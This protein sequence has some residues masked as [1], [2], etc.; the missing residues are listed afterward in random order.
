M[1]AMGE[2]GATQRRAAFKRVMEEL[3]EKP[4]SWAKS[5]GLPNANALYNFL[6]GRSDSLSTA[7]LEAL[8]SCKNLTVSQVVGETAIRSRVNTADVE[9]RGE[10]QAGVWKEA[11]E[12]PLEDRFRITTVIEPAQYRQKAYGLR[13]CGNSMNEFYADGDILICVSIWDLDDAILHEDHVIVHRVDKNGLHEATCKE[14]RVDDSGRGWLVA[15]SS[16]PEFQERAIPI[17]WPY[18]PDQP[19][20]DGTEAVQITAVVIGSHRSRRRGQQR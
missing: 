14:V 18:D 3:D 9:V 17:P 12:L 1:A 2:P 15:R 13:N 5:A 20:E 11:L 19:A 10:V 16:D 6:N 7:T 4:A 8:A